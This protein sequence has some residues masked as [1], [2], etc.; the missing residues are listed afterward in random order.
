MILEALH[1]E[2][3]WNFVVNVC[4]ENFINSWKN[5]WK[6]S[7]FIFHIFSTK[8]LIVLTLQIF[9]SLSPSWCS[10]M[11]ECTSLSILQCLLCS[12]L[13]EKIFCTCGVFI[14]IVDFEVLHVGTFKFQLICQGPHS[15]GSW[16]HSFVGDMTATSDKNN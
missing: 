1:T 4:C 3:C 6:K 11:A 5:V 12:T 8:Q 7:D 16:F 10:L 14:E 2:N 15:R 9:F 13:S